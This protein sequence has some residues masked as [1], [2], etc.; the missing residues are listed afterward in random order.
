MTLRRGLVLSCFA[1]LGCEGSSELGLRLW[2]APIVN[3]QT[4]GGHPSVGLLR[5]GAQSIC[6]ATLVGKKT[7]LTAGHCVV[8]GAP[9]SAYVLELGGQRYPA[10]SV[11]RHPEFSQNSKTSPPQKDLTVV[12][13]A[14]APP[15]TPS[16][17]S[18]VAPAVGLELTLV[19]FGV[20]AEPPAG[21]Q[22]EGAGTK[23]MARNKIA[24]V[25]ETE[26]V[27]VGST[28]AVGNTCYGDS[29]GP[30]FATING[31]EV[32]VGVTSWGKA[33]CGTE[34]HDARVDRYVDWISQTAGGDVVTG[35]AAP[36]ADTQPPKVSILSPGTGAATSATVTVKAEV[37]DNV[38]VA[39]VELYLNDRLK[40]TLNAGPFEFQLS[41][42]AGAN[43]VKVVGH[44]A[45]GNKGEASILL[46]LAAGPTPGTGPGTDPKTAEPPKP[47]EYGATCKDPGECKSGLCAE[48]PAAAGKYCTD[49]CTPGTATGCPGQAECL[50]TAKGDEHV[51]S[52]PPA[53]Q[54]AQ[55]GGLTA[56]R[57]FGGCAVA[58][59]AGSPGAQ[60]LAGW[61][62]LGLG[63]GFRRLRRRRS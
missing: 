28:G 5:I 48:D 29:G 20:I 35:G 62:V 42:G 10:A 32:Q 13:L 9:A 15:V 7:V 47:G 30:A 11:V 6:T 53:G 39:K 37:T 55:S 51:C 12:L 52:A 59:G 17:I 2:E 19:G 57:L 49:R 63:L 40:Q 34:A 26:V 36:V 31:Q 25:T 18:A 38:G 8:V 27:F 41:L 22:G 60:D 16:A 43:N 58:D 24:S 46:E 3:G 54:S 1:L 21:Q 61:L 44:D 33:P 45:A 14:S 56:G 4:Y 23:R 50:A